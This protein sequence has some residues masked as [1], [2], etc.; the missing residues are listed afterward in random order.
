MNDLWRTPL[1]LKEYFKDYYDP[2]PSNPDFDGLSI[3][4]KSPAFVNPPYSRGN[5]MLWVK[6]AIEQ[7]QKGVYVVMLLRVDVSTNWYRF[8]VESDCHI[9]YFNERLEFQDSNGSPNFCS[10][11]VFLSQS[12]P[13]EPSLRKGID[14]LSN[15]D[16]LKV[17]YKLPSNSSGRD[18]LIHY[19]K[20]GNIAT[21]CDKYSMLCNTTTN[22]KDVDCPECLKHKKVE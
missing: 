17:D 4:W 9:A 18:T 8:L 10:M 5:V 15:P 13:K 12:N 21:K 2:C 7:Q 14:R 19:R 16:A 1:W 22:W 3:D 6:K 11:L 20:L